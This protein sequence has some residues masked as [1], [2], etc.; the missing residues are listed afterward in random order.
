ML[1]VTVALEADLTANVPPVW[2]VNESPAKVV[3]P[4]E[5]VRRLNAEEYVLP[6]TGAAT[7]LQFVE[8]VKL[9]VPF[10]SAAFRVMLAA[11][12]LAVTAGLRHRVA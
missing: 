9:D 2:M 12:I 1:A 6:A 11:A 10:A 5:G 7:M 3:L 4:D 8:P